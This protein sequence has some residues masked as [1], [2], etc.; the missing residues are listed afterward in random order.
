MKKLIIASLI[1]AAGTLSSAAFAQ[2][3]VGAAAGQS[4]IDIDCA[5]TTSCDTKDTGYKVYAGYMFTPNFGIEGAYV[6]LGK[7]KASGVDVDLGDFSASGKADGFG[8]WGVA[9]APFD[10]FNVFVKLGFASMKTKIDATSS[11]RGNASDSNTSTEFAWGVGA[12]YEFTKNFGAR[13]EFERFRLKIVDEK[14][15]A[16][17]ISLGLTYRF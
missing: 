16:D 13:V 3:Y 7:A 12:G 9:M 10:Q 1:A 6:D 14:R 17:L 15:D 2:G 5:G 4:D 11:L 8:L